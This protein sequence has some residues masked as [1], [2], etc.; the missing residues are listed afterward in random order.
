ME[1]KVNLIHISLCITITRIKSI[2]LKYPK[3]VFCMPL[4]KCV[5]SKHPGSSA[6]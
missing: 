3:Q 1:M 4:E 5:Q 6:N 2:K